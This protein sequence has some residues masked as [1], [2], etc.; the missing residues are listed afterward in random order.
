MITAGGALDPAVLRRFLR[1]W[2]VLAASYCAV[3][4]GGFGLLSLL[5]NPAEAWR[6]ALKV[7]LVLSFALLFLLAR[8]GQMLAGDNLDR[9]W[10]IANSL[11]LLRGVL[12]ALLSGFLFAPPPAGAAAWLPALIFTVGI[13]A[14]FLDG[15]WARRTASETRM[16]ALLDI[17][18]DGVGILLAVGLAVQYGRL[19]PLFLAVGA[20]RYV[21]VAASAARRW[22][23]RPV[24]DLPS[25]YL[26]R[27]LAGFQMV[28]LAL[29]LWPIASPPTTTLVEALIAI[30][31]LAG[32]TR[33]WLLA[34][35]RIDPG[36]PRYRQ[37]L[38]AAAR[39]AY[40]WFPLALRGVLAAA[41][42]VG[43]A[44][45]AS[46]PM[47]LIALRCLAA[48]ALLLG[49]QATPAAL[50]LLLLESLR[51]FL[52]VPD[53]AGLTVLSCALLLCVL[54]PG[55]LALDGRRKAGR[56]REQ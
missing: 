1:G 47:P 54:G 52:D 55:A 32:F 45:S 4:A 49:W 56:H 24:F 53:A 38:A 12:F 22:R 7:G 50:V 17:E 6:W 15:W 43:L 35:G 40:R 42:V 25:S 16:G 10:G 9:I 20:A 34:S 3:A 23:G 51:A 11:T 33:D 31:L 13:V 44:A 2:L 48:G 28:V 37:A 36:D 8:R 39:A 5:R 29:V 41:A 14:D 18:L 26:R 19:P 21:F 30:P 27:R 46:A